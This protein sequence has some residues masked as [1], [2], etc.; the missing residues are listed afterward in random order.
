MAEVGAAACAAEAAEDFPVERGLAADTAGEGM[1]AAADTGAAGDMGAAV[2]AGLVPV[3]RILAADS[4]PRRDDRNLRPELAPRTAAAR[5]LAALVNALAVNALAVNV[6]ALA[7]LAVSSAALAQAPQAV[8]TQPPAVIN[9]AAS[10]ACRPTKGCPAVAPAQ[11]ARPVNF[12]RATVARSTSTREPRKAR[13]AAK[14]RGSPSP[15][16][17]ETQPVA[18]SPKV[19]TAASPQRA[20]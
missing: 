14:R 5:T 11:V 4:A 16:R 6:R 8:D 17:V 15:D 20:A 13:A 19:P 7:R 3:R 1:A 12:P 9:S 2:M 10:S 18:P